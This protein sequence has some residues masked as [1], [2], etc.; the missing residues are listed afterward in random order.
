[1]PSPFARDAARAAGAATLGAAGIALALAGLN[2]LVSE[3]APPP[4]NPLGVEPQAYAWTDGECSYSVSGKG[5]AVLLLHGIY[6]GASSYEFRRVFA[7]LARHF[8]VFAPDL[9]GFGLSA[10]PA[11]VYHPDL[12]IEF[13][14][15]FARQVAGG[16]DHPVYVIA[17][18][19]TCAYVTEA[20]AA[21]PDLFDRLILI[22]PT[23]I[24]ELAAKPTPGQRFLGDLMR[25]PLVGTT[26]YHLLVSRPGLRYFLTQQIYKDKSE[27]TDDL[28]D[29]YYAISHQPNARFA[30]ASFIG[31]LLNLDIAN[32]FQMLKQPILICWGRRSRFSPLELAE[33]FLERNNRVELAIF[34]HSS[35]L[36]HDEEADDF[37][38]QVL[39]WLRTSISSR[40]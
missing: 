15:D 29:E 14:Q 10:R 17:S 34:D 18:S 16:A 24:Q 1:M 2:K 36:P 30:T 13:I 11:R 21:R 28:I 23:G 9:P 22:E 31:G 12:Y 33:A 26:L 38:T 40:Y 39:G 32:T 4:Q 27:V 7:P 37:L 5:P 25:A 35:A 6:A 3:S 20:V 8:R 19:L